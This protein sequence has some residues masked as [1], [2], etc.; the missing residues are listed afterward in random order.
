[1]WNPW[2]VCTNTPAFILLVL[3]W[4]MVNFTFLLVEFYALSVP[5]VRLVSPYSLRVLSTLLHT[6]F[7]GRTEVHWVSVQLS[8]SRREQG[9]RSQG[10]T[11]G[12]TQSRG[13]MSACLHL[14][15]T[16]WGL[17][18]TFHPVL[19]GSCLQWLEGPAWGF[20]GQGVKEWGYT[21]KQLFP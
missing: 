11:A 10:G 9:L 13:I 6:A 1:M 2:S 18:F 15:K 20:R 3:M 12:I 14:P 16:P 5:L 21:Q 17:G 7:W 4:H 19:E 8:S